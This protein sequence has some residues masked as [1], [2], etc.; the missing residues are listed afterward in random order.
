MQPG[1]LT[2]YAA[3]QF[4][5]DAPDYLPERQTSE[6]D[7]GLSLIGLTPTG[8]FFITDLLS[9]SPGFLLLPLHSSE[10]LPLFWMQNRLFDTF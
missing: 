7:Q 2:F 5:A 4:S 10:G 3:R 9:F 6:F 1:F 8:S